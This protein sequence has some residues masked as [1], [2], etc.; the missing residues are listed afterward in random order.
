MNRTY[1]SPK[2]VVRQSNKGGKGLFA[3]KVI[4][5]GEIIAIKNGHFVDSHEATI[6]D[7]E[8][9]DFSLQISDEFFI[10]PKTKEEIEDTAIFINHSCDPNIG[11][12]GQISYVAMRNIQAG[13]ELCLDYAMAMTTDY[14]L[15]CSC[16]SSKCRKL[17]TGEDWKL[18]ELQIRYDIYFSW[19]IYKKIHNL[20]KV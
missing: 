13:E 3:K 11:M 12:N 5:P 14:K 1:R 17:I 18:K 15:N 16:G 19:F 4:L 9:G 20:D 6:L 8:L 10:C 2:T 7:S